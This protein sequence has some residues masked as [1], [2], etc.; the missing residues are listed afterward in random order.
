MIAAHLDNLLFLL[1]IAVALLF[2]LLAKAG[3]K[4]SKDQTKRTPT[5]QTPKPIPRAP[6]ES[7]EE[8]IRK[9]LEALGQPPTSRPP[10]LV[11]PRTD[12]PP[13]PL[14]PVQ[15]PM[16]PL[17]QLRREK[18]RKREVIPKEIPPPR[19]VRGTEK[20][21]P[22]VFEVHEGPFLI[23]PPPIFK[24]PAESYARVTPTIAEAEEPRRDIATLLASTS[25]LRDAMVLREILGPPRGLR[26]LDSV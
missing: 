5:P 2:Q 17:S 10:P 23:V 6:T 15:P 1:L 18:S 25:G 26:M 8:R 22:P 4:A 24:A 14:A 19:T 21:V 20:V 12:I 11:V 9:L 16:S 3:G 7:D 13:R